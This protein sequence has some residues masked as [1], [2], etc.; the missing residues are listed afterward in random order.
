MGQSR[1]KHDASQYED[2]IICPSFA[3]RQV[4]IINNINYMFKI[5]I[6]KTVFMKS[7]DFFFNLSEHKLHPLSNRVMQCLNQLFDMFRKKKKIVFYKLCLTRGSASD[8]CM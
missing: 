8:F 7:Q 6:K 3:Y 5:E 2:V 4:I 1:K